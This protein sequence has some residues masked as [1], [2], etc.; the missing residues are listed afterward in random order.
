[1]RFLNNAENADSFIA[2][3]KRLSDSLSELNAAAPGRLSRSTEA[4]PNCFNPPPMYENLI[5]LSV[6]QSHYENFKWED[7]FSTIISFDEYNYLADNITCYLSSDAIC[8]KN[9]ALASKKTLAF[10]Q[11]Y[12]ARGAYSIKIQTRYRRKLAVREVALRRMRDFNARILQ[13]N[14]RGM[15]GRAKAAALRRSNEINDTLKSVLGSNSSVVKAFIS[16]TTSREAYVAAAESLSVVNGSKNG[17][18]IMFDTNA[19]VFMVQKMMSSLKLNSVVNR[20]K[21]GKSEWAI[22]VK[23]IGSLEL[24][25]TT[26]DLVTKGGAGKCMLDVL[27]RGD[28]GVREEVCGAIAKLSLDATLKEYF[29]FRMQCLSTL[30]HMLRSSNQ[31]VAEFSS[32]DGG[33]VN[34]PSLAP[35]L[36]TFK[37]QL[38]V[39]EAVSVILSRNS[40]AKDEQGRSLSTRYKYAMGRNG[41]LPQILVILQSTTETF[42]SV[43]EPDHYTRHKLLEKA[44]KILW[45]L[46]EVEE[47]YR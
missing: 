35:L 19:V 5:P 25:D 1:M 3:R 11:F 14:A 30:N 15:C 17:T 10:Y 2:V 39:I 24:N 4:R 20:T 22:F 38:A 7:F 47:N 45:K 27:R 9:F 26:R 18:A 33:E 16:S 31:A 41:F 12:V 13:R 37:H 29:V 34:D 40:T 42:T 46:V 32:A 23:L 36:Y 6:R 43:Q 44:C 21:S 28:S 8:F